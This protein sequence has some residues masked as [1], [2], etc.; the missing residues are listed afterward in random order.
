MPLHVGNGSFSPAIN[1]NNSNSD[2]NPIVRSDTPPE[3]SGWDKIKA[4]FAPT[5]RSE[6][7]ECIRL[8]CH[9]P[10]GT[11]R[12]A[13]VNRFEQLRTLAHPVFRENIQS[14]RHGE[15]HFCILDANSQEI[16]TVTVDNSGKYD[17][18][19]G[20]YKETHA[21]TPRTTEDYEAVWSAWEREAPFEERAG[22]AAAVQKMRSCLH[23]DFWILQLFT[24]NISSLPDHL[25]PCTKEIYIQGLPLTSLPEL[26]HGLTVL[27]VGDTLLTSL[28]ALPHSLTEL[29][30]ADT[31][32]TSLPELPHS[33]TQ[34][35]IASAPLTSL[36][37]LPHGL[38]LL[39]VMNTSLASL[40]ALPHGL[41]GLSIMDN[42]LTSLPELPHGLTNLK[43][44]DTPLTHLPELPHGLVHLLVTNT[45]LTSLP[46]SLTDLPGEAFVMLRRNPLSERTL[47]ALH[48]INSAPD[49]SGPR[50]EFDMNGSAVPWETRALHLAVADWL[51]PAKE[52]KSASANRW[53]TFGQEEDA[54]AFSS[55][56]D[57]LSQTENFK[58][59]PGFKAQISPW[60][61][62]L[63]EDG[64]LRAKSFAMAAEATSSCE[65]RVT[66][67]LNQMKNVHL[68]H[69]AEK[70]AFDG[71]IPGL[72]S[73]GREMFR[74]EKLEQ[75]A[76]EKVQTLYFVDE[77][78]VFLGYQ[79]KLKEPLGLTSVTAEMRFFGVSHI[80]DSDLQAAE[81]QV[82]TAENSQ[83]GEWMLQ[84]EPLRSLL[85]R[86][87]PESWEAL[88]EKKISDYGNAFQTLSDIELKPAGLVGDAEAERTI[89]ARAMD[90]A[91]KAFLDGLRPMA[92]KMLGS[93]SKPDA[94]N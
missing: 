72:V 2:T 69:N 23:N 47:Q 37:E 77:I 73:V 22:R 7:Q 80:T 27:W 9:P 34:L 14:H 86:T 70:G 64:E 79:N 10:V 44:L 40:P 59:D 8:I 61:T 41:T 74:L 17:V 93:L 4:F 35:D 3:M 84:W 76:R 6:A 92:D 11:T 62:Q 68:V 75:I 19:C 43:V 24:L 20:G 67:A 85:K 12:G 46:E 54:A 5:Q 52:G 21:T 25:P 57:R 26:P 49:Y 82:K 88:C 32:L 78:E 66:L 30:I 38:A 33:L 94:L 36:P 56:L 29:D 39:S 63:A 91:E 58:K 15:N 45:S 55:F 16:L 90:S 42:T 31:P 65:D 60:L 13:V 48:N 53:Q 18:K 87:E 83:F 51:P 71:N 81:I 1:H 28:P 50:I 89:G